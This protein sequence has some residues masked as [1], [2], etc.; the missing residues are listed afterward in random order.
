MRCRSYGADRNF[1]GVQFR[2]CAERARNTCRADTSRTA[3]KNG[4]NTHPAFA[5]GT[6]GGF[7]P[8]GGF[9][10]SNEPTV[11]LVELRFEVVCAMLELLIEDAPTPINIATVIAQSLRMVFRKL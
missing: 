9:L 7:L 11:E 8:T 1:P 3:R 4:S 10:F 2:P 6:T 5:S